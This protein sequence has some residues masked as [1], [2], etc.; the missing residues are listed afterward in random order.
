MQYKQLEKTNWPPK[1]L[2]GSL[3]C[4]INAECV[5]FRFR[6]VYFHR[7]KKFTLL[8]MISCTAMISRQCFR[9]QFLIG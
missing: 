8:K 1:K 9:L 5:R 4:S 7:K 2:A 3:S 6:M